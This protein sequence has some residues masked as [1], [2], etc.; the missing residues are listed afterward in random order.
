MKPLLGLLAKS[1]WYRRDGGGEI[2]LLTISW[3]DTEFR[4]ELGDDDP[5]L[6]PTPE[7]IPLGRILTLTGAQ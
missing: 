5:I 6:S 1:S 2:T 7:I 4:V 3:V